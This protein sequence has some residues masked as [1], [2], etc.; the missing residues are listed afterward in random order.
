MRK[1]YL[2]ALFDPN[3]KI[4]K[5]IGITNNPDR[6]YL[7]HLEDTNNTKKT[8][9]IQSL[10]QGNKI[11]IMKVVK[12]TDDVHKVIEWEKLYIAKL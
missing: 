9:W 1:Y 6:R 10:K 2:Y 7:E 4:P 11:P 3:L 5:Y 8:R 12:D